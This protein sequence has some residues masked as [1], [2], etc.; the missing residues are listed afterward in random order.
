MR[1]RYEKP[2]IEVIELQFA[3]IV[4]LS[5]QSGGGYIGGC[6]NDLLQP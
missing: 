2:E 3:D 6:D 4:T 5:N 1:E